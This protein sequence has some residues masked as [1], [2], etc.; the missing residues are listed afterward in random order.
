MAYGS[1]TVQREGAGGKKNG[2]GER[3]DAPTSSKNLLGGRSGKY[4]DGE[5]ALLRSFCN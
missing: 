2:K 5:F 1:W 4:E 3:G